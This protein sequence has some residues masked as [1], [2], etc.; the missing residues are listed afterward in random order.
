M[1]D[2]H[3][4]VMA[5]PG[6][7]TCPSAIHADSRRPPASSSAH[8]RRGVRRFA[9]SARVRLP[10]P[11][12]WGLNAKNSNRGCPAGDSRRA[13]CSSSQSPLRLRELEIRVTFVGAVIHVLRA[14][15]RSV[16]KRSR[17]FNQPDNLRDPNAP[18]LRV[19]ISDGARLYVTLA[20]PGSPAR[21]Y[22]GVGLEDVT[23][24]RRTAR[25]LDRELA[26]RQVSVKPATSRGLGGP[27]GSRFL[28]LE[29]SVTALAREIDLDAA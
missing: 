10:P 20:A 24:E 21:V 23:S 4:A 6:T 16:K 1:N 25:D 27:E 5:C 12:S 22:G 28:R 13:I 18:N 8:P 14:S 15:V 29:I 9:P 19:V 2:R 3:A 11:T 26:T 7:P 17:D